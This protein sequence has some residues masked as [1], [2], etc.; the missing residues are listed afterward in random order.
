MTLYLFDVGPPLDPCQRIPREQRCI[1]AGAANGRGPAGETC[2]T[3]VHCS[4]VRYRDYVYLKCGLAN[5]AWTYGRGS[6][7]FSSWPACEE[8]EKEP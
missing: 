1:P 4:R 7:I 5:N 2:G 3:C 6:D 8:W